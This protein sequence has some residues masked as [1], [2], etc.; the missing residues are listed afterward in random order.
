MKKSFRFLKSLSVV[1]LAIYFV[2]MV[3]GPSWGLKGVI[4]AE[5]N[6]SIAYEANFRSSVSVRAD[7]DEYLLWDK[8]RALKGEWYGVEEEK[9]IGEATWYQIIFMSNHLFE[10]K[11]IGKE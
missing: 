6:K 11:I 3:A 1:I 7:S 9:K 4:F 2:S 10:D 5:D 8:Y